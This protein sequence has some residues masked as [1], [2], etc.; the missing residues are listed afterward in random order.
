[1]EFLDQVATF[2]SDF[3]DPKKRVF[4]GYLAL[5]VVIAV[6]WLF[7]IQKLRP[8]QA[9]ARIFDRR[10]LFSESAIAD[11]K[12]FFFN[13]IFSL[14]ISPLLIS[15]MAIA[16]SIY[17][18][19]HNQ[20]F[21]EPGSFDG[22]GTGSIVALFSLWLFLVDDFTKYLVHRWMHKWPLLW[23]I[24]KVH[25]S[26][27]TL[28]PI[29]VYRVHP[30]EGVLYSLRGVV[31]QGSTLSVFFYLFGNA[32]DLYTVLGVNVIVFI[33]H[34]TGSNLRHSHISIRYWR[35]LEFILISPAQHQLHHSIAEEHYDKNFGVALAIW[36]WIFGSLH[37]S[38]KDDDLEFGVTDEPEEAVDQLRTIYFR[39]VIEM[40]DI[41]KRSILRTVVPLRS[42]RL[43]GARQSPKN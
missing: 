17:F 1:M 12:I 16:T 8:R 10:I 30:L 15:Q 31:A 43:F 29:T 36:D 6:I 35:W 37:L 27:K 22:L 9:F 34:V 25:H 39:P 41:S 3:A 2:F 11:Y 19:L 4:V 38:H 18:L 20:G 13:R 32:V 7:S 40:M 23:A 5:S 24:H 42:A 28:T 14:L 26:A 21:V 33:F